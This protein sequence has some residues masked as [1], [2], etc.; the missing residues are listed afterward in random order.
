MYYCCGTTD[1]GNVRDNNEDAYM[2]NRIVMTQATMESNLNAPFI[3][4]VADGVAGET[5]GEVASKLALELLCSTKYNKK[6]DLSKKILN[7]HRYLRRYGITHKSV[8]M[9]TTL[10]ALAVDE[11]NKAV[12]ANVGDSRMYLY[13]RNNIKQLSTD[14]SLVQMLY[15]NGHIT[16][17]EQQN[18]SK[19]HII[20]PV[21][22]HLTVDPQIEITQIENGICYGDL[23]IICSDGLSDYLTKG[24][25]ENILA[26]PMRLPKRLSMLIERAKENGSPDNITVLGI[27]TYEE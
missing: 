22:G 27:S 20:F 10:C 26:E 6:T 18:H 24:E 8:N 16:K 15:E 11:D 13:K 9:Q 21:L 4:G 19:R 12:L 17:Q 14:Q 1:I 3:I 2:I 7:I 5:S 23:I 25:F